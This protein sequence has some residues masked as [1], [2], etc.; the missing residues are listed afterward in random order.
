MT[1]IQDEFDKAWKTGDAKKVA[2]L[3]HPEAAFVCT[4][5]WAVNG[6][7]AIEEK[8]AAIIDPKAE[9][10]IIFDLNLEAGDGEYL[11]HKG[12]FEAK[13]KPG[14]LLPYEQIYKR[15]ADGTYLIYHDE[16]SI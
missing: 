1:K 16:F 4:G 9:F 12:R 7:K 13:D 14:V 8:Y 6:R 11:I 5:Q 15:Q 3:Y 10:N 2:E